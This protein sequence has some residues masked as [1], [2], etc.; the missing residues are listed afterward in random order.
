[1]KKQRFHQRLRPA[2][3]L[4]LAIST[5]LIA[6]LPAS[7]S[8][9]G[10]FG[11]GLPDDQGFSAISLFPRLVG[12]LISIQI[13]FNQHLT[14]AVHAMHQNADAFWTLLGLS[15]AYGI[16]HAAGPGHGKAVVSSYVLATR[17]TLR[18]GVVLALIT[19]LAQAAGAIMLILVAS[20]VLHMTSVS[21]TWTTFQFE[22]VSDAFVLLL[23]CWLVWT[24]I[25]KPARSLNL[26]FEP[27]TPLTQP[28]LYLQ[29]A[30]GNQRSRFLA[31][32]VGGAANFSGPSQRPIAFSASSSADPCDCGSLHIPD[33]SRTDG[34][35]D[36]RKAWTIV[37]S[38]ALRPCT[39]ALI[40][41]V[42][43]ISQGLLAAGIAAVITMGLGTAVTVAALA[44][45]AVS[46]RKT[47]FVLTG[48]DS[49]LGH[50]IK[51]AV[52]VGAALIVVVA[53][54]LLL[55]GDVFLQ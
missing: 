27:I 24:K 35:L 55:L 47:A 34:T 14:A 20:M 31:S 36:W 51:R 25:I 2:A 19:S 37:A 23:G 43:S 50:K 7:A 33:A 21:I 17:Q 6:A 49:A 3:S 40:V 10:P 11:T 29:A 32:E 22:V 42:F 41:L 46:A 1:M 12:F 9:T 53:G 16:A 48:A 5:A 28:Q 30:Q 54:L 4:S 8:P 38:T 45:L 39:G 26:P 52:E 18:N 15:F 44:T 13:Y